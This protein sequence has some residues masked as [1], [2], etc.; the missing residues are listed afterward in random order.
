MCYVVGVRGRKEGDGLLEV[1]TC[2]SINYWDFFSPSFVVLPLMKPLKLNAEKLLLV[3]FVK[4]KKNV[5]K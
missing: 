5:K 2:Q 4:I 3:K 1:C